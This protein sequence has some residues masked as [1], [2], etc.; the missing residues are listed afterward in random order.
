MSRTSGIPKGIRTHLKGEGRVMIYRELVRLAQREMAELKDL[1]VDDEPIVSI[2]D[3]I[4]TISQ[5]EFLD[6][7]AETAAGIFKE[8]LN[9]F[10]EEPR[11]PACS[12]GHRPSLAKR[13][14]DV[15]PDKLF[16]M[17]KPTDFGKG[18]KSLTGLFDKPRWRH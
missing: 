6:E 13:E 14:E 18:Y 8:L 7:A 10:I 9:E 3:G 1:I 2:K 11:K 4:V 12:C 17:T 5:P 16:L 15:S